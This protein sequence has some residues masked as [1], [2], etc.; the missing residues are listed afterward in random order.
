M[1]YTWNGCQRSEWLLCLYVCIIRVVRGRKLYEMSEICCMY[2]IYTVLFSRTFC[3]IVIATFII[4]TWWW[5]LTLH[6]QHISIWGVDSTWT[7]TAISLENIPHAPYRLNS[8]LLTVIHK[9]KNVNLTDP[10]ATF[11]SGLWDLNLCSKTQNLS[12]TKM[13]RLKCLFS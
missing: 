5:T 1:C 8:R 2:N 10:D 12:R 11:T 9:L 4:I 6:K 7:T 13:C 3:G